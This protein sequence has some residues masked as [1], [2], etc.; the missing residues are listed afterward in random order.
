MLAAHLFRVVGGTPPSLIDQNGVTYV[1]E[2]GR[3][4][5]GRHPESDVLVDQDFGD[6]SRAHLLMDWRPPGRLEMTDLSTRGTYL[7]G[8]VVAR[9]QDPPID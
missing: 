1:L 5:I 3:K 2:E 8:S 9:S 6:V 4:M 7:R